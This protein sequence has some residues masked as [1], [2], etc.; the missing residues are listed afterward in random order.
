[1]ARAR[2]IDGRGL[3]RRSFSKALAAAALGGCNGAIAMRGG[4]MGG[5][6]ASVVTGDGGLGRD[7]PSVAQDAGPLVRSCGELW[8]PE[9]P[10]GDPVWQLRDHAGTALL[11]VGS[12]R[13]ELASQPELLAPIR[14]SK[15]TAAIYR[16]STGL[17]YHGWGDWNGV[18]NEGVDG[19]FDQGGGSANP[20]V[21]SWTPDDPTVMTR[22][23]GS[24]PVDVEAN[25][26][27]W[28]V[29]ADEGF[30]L[31]DSVDD[32]ILVCPLTAF[33]GEFANPPEPEVPRLVSPD[34]IAFAGDVT[35][36]Y[37][38]RKKVLVFMDHPTG[39]ADTTK[40]GRI[41][42]SV[43]DGGET[44]ITIAWIDTERPLTLES[45]TRVALSSEV[46]VGGWLI[47]EPTFPKYDEARERWYIY[48]GSWDMDAR[49]WT[50]VAFDAPTRELATSA[51]KAAVFA[52]PAVTGRG[53]EV[54][55]FGSDEAGNGR[56]FV[57]DFAAQTLSV[58]SDEW[59]SGM[60]HAS[61]HQPWP[62]T[63]GE[64]YAY[65]WA[66]I[67]SRVVRW[68]LRD[69]VGTTFELSIDGKPITSANDG[70]DTYLGN[71]AKEDG[72]HC[73]WNADIRRI[74]LW[75]NL[76]GQGA[77]SFMQIFF[78]DPAAS[79]PT[80]E[81]IAQADQNGEPIR[82]NNPIHV[83][84]IGATPARTL[85][86]GDHTFDLER[87]PPPDKLR[88]FIGANHCADSS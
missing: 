16:P 53:K 19:F 37:A 59:S 75:T 25:D 3:S 56:V 78:V 15:H 80:I 41:T 31:Y 85:C 2:R 67:E 8:G 52:A 1:M 13:P 45:P 55:A 21:A 87:T 5:G 9:I 58:S 83:P 81:L 23:I 6:D 24:L 11:G 14:G 50:P 88:T 28:Y 42:E 36:K 60:N 32:R 27:A 29:R 61:C 66:W 46:G 57:F 77:E 74:E 48:L 30:V 26:R 84:R 65:T 38:V 70:T 18:N 35:A 33:G 79:P 10:Y 40:R 39:G 43:H 63:D 71:Q 69:R 82:T 64:R 54:H 7:A 17:V 20:F 76:R 44:T 12:P 22:E 68:D 4:V 72:I 47:Q 62:C 34:Q 73:I 86:V 49:R 51:F